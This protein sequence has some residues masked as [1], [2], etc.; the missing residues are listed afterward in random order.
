MDF[1]SHDALHEEGPLILRCQLQDFDFLR[2][3][4][5]QFRPLYGCLFPSMTGSESMLMFS[6]VLLP[7]FRCFACLSL[8]SSS[9]TFGL[10]CSYK[11]SPIPLRR[12]YYYYHAFYFLG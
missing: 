4:L 2:Q 9:G 11:L 5:K 6:I 1:S 8:G 3:V 7:I 10:F 12:K